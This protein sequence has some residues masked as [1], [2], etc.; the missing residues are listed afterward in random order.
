MSVLYHRTG[1]NFNIPF[2]FSGGRFRHFLISHSQTEDVLVVRKFIVHL[3]DIPADQ[4]LDLVGI[5]GTEMI[6]EIGFFIYEFRAQ[7]KIFIVAVSVARLAV[8]H[9]L[10]DIG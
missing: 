10:S 2:N 5:P 6:A 7:S 9:V 1:F 8:H 4:R 3:I